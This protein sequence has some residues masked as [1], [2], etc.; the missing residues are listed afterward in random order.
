VICRCIK[1]TSTGV[2]VFARWLWTGLLVVACIFLPL[3]SQAQTP[4]SYIITTVAGNHTSGFAG[5]GGAA[6]SGTLFNPSSVAVDNS[7]NLYIADQFNNRVRKVSADGTITTVA[8]NG[9]GSLLGDGGQATSA[10]LHNPFGVAVDSSGNLYVAD[11]S[12]NAVRKVGTN[13]VITTVVGNGTFGYS[14]DGGPA[15]NATLEQPVA[16]AVDKAGNLY[17]ADMTNNVIRKVTT[18]GKIFTIAG[19]GTFGYSGDGG[20]ATSTAFRRPAGVAVDS[21]GNLYIADSGNHIVRKVT[22]DGTI[23]T[24]AGNYSKGAGF[25][26]DGGLATAAQLNRPIGLAVDAAGNLFIADYNNSRIRVV[27]PNGMITTVAGTGYFG[28]DGDGGPATNAQLCFPSGV[29]VD[30]MGDVYIADNQNHVIRKL[31]PVPVS[32]AAPV[33]NEG[34]VISASAFGAFGSAAPG[35]WIEIYG[36]NLSTE[37]RAWTN[38]DFNGV[39]APVL[40]GGTTV[41]IGGRAAFLSYVSPGQINAQVPTD[42]GPGPVELTVST[43]NGTSAPYTL[44]VKDVQ[45]GLFAPP[46]FQIGG[47]QYVGALFPDGVT[48]VLPTGAVA[49]VTSRPAHPN[50]TIILYGVG[51]GPVSPPIPA[52]QL[53]QQK[54]TLTTPLQI[55]IGQNPA[56]LTYVGLAPGLVGVYQFNVV[57]PETASND[58]APVEFILGGAKGQQTLYIAIQ[59]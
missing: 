1:R 23:T 30:A 8:G 18:D 28:Y 37:T 7:G 16:V 58:A 40:L 17:I 53:V 13:G 6:T 24:I 19:N 39:N 26:G 27:T 10:S 12:N 49:G 54:N 33:I 46:S 15:S 38:A 29:A 36:S 20:S 51:F 44:M 4:P 2:G 48:F 31:T 5:D 34:G 35:S 41:T 14:G 43:V 11:T 59:N 55:S 9:T 22:P 52:G 50:E 21:A 3:A 42:V 25:S 47:K 56:Q 32:G 57:V 45:P